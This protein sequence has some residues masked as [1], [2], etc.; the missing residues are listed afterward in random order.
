MYYK[1]PVLIVV[2]GITLRVSAYGYQLDLL[3]TSKGNF[4]CYTLGILE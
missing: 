3:V 2:T 1:G 4:V